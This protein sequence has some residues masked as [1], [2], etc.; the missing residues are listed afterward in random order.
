MRLPSDIEMKEEQEL[1]TVRLDASWAEGDS[2]GGSA[3]AVRRREVCMRRRSCGQWKQLI[4]LHT[5]T[6]T[7]AGQFAKPN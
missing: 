5:A 4:P 2:G 7:Y 6:R 1:E 3:V